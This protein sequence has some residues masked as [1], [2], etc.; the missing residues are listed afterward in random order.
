MPHALQRQSERAVTYAD[1]RSALR[2]ARAV[3]P[4]Q[5]GRWRL[6]GGMDLDGDE[7]TV[8]IAIRVRLIVITV[9]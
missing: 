4:A 8:V 2:T 1:L 7:I 5:W 3:R 6:L 9:Y